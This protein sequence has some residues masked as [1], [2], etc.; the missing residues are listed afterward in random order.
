MSTIFEVPS[1]WRDGLMPARFRQA[2]FH[3]EMNARESGRRTVEHEFPKKT[4]PYAEDMGRRARDF[5]IRGYLVVY[6]HDPNND[7]PIFRAHRP[8][9]LFQYDY[10]IPRDA[11]IDALE[12]EGPG[13]LQLPTQ[14]EQIVVCTRYRLT[15]EDKTGGYCAIDMT[16][17][18][19]GLDPLIMA[20]PA[21][22]ETIVQQMADQLRQQ[23]QRRLAPPDPSI[24]TG[25]PT[26][27][28]VSA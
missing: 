16:F 2:Y 4:L 26:Q 21:N 8:N 1:A 24:G 14:Q 12:L 13:T 19:Y 3:C 5:T 28:T 23:V 7:D 25:L 27:T 17:Q 15:E 6:P 18:E 20:A 22:T 10:R 9:D 11:L